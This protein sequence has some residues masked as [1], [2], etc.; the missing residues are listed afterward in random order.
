MI[1]LILKLNYRY[2]KNAKKLSALFRDQPV[3]PLE[4]AKYWIEYVIRNKGAPHMRSSALDLN[5]FQYHNLDVYAAIMVTVFILVKI[6]I[7]IPKL[8]ISKL[9]KSGNKVK[10]S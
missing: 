1:K 3:T 6:I 5:F 10:M 2:A 4:T 9:T 7:V 8:V